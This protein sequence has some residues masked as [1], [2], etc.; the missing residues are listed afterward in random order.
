MN[1]RYPVHSTWPSQLCGNALEDK[2]IRWA[3]QGQKKELWSAIDKV[4]DQAIVP[5]DDQAVAKVDD[6][7]D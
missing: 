1:S 6:Q 5:V 3:G 7:V 4:D 2:G